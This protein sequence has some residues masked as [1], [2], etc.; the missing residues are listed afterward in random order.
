MSAEKLILCLEKLQKLHES[1][2]ALA[3]E[4]TEAVKKQEIERLQK[5]TQEE[6]AHIRAIGALE[7]ERETLAKTLTGG[8]GTLSDCIA[9]VSGEARSQLETLRDSLIGITK[10]L[11]QQNELNQMLL[12]HSL[13]FTQFM[14]DLIYP[15]NEP[16]T[17]GPPSGQK[18]A[19]AMPRFDSKA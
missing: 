17:Y 11:K 9:A 12:Y 13:Q 15:K 7:Q 3:A 10:K 8:N 4:K 5:I 14:L 6:Q 18:A 1:L 16:T 19:A 2:F